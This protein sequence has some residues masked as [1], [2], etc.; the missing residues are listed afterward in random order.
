MAP[1]SSIPRT[2]VR[3]ALK[4]LE[5]LGTIMELSFDADRFPA[6]ANQK[7]QICASS[8]ICC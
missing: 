3:G 5:K 6:R 4:P 1:A 7:R 2:G 8:E